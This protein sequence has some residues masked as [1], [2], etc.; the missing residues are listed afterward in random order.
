MTEGFSRAN[1]DGLIEWVQENADSL[2][3]DGM[4]RLADALLRVSTETPNGARRI[5]IDNLAQTDADE[6]WALLNDIAQDNGLVW[7]WEVDGHD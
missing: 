7:E 5:D 4:V 6:L 1:L 2:K 3:G